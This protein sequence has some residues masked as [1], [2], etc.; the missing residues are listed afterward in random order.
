MFLYRHG[1][2]TMT[3]TYGNFYPEL[4]VFDWDGNYIGGFK[5][6]RNLHFIEYDE[7]HNVLYGINIDEE[8]YAYDMETLMP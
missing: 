5:M 2:Y 1:K 7:I 8:L 3:T 4:L 6:D